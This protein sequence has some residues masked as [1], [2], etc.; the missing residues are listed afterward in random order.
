V[1][2]SPIKTPY[3]AL[4]ARIE[5]LN[6]LEMGLPLELAHRI[7]VCIALQAKAER[8]EVRART[9]RFVTMGLAIQVDNESRKTLD[10]IHAWM[11]DPKRSKP[12]H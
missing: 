1:E 12:S 10:A 2:N 3:E 11:T 6:D 9:A 8:A 4:E 7:N 5:E